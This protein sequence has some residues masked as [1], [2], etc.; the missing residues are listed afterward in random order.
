MLDY[1]IH[2]TLSGT[3]CFMPIALI[4]WLSLFF[5]LVVRIGNKSEFES[6]ELLLSTPLAITAA[7]IAYGVFFVAPSGLRHIPWHT[8]IVVILLGTQLLQ[9]IALVSYLKGVR[10]FAVFILIT[11][12][13]MSCVAG[14]EATMSATGR[15]L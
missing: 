4:T 5:A 12:I 2:S 14:L 6:R 3:F 15:W 8:W 9:S 11:E 7:L 1:M 13:C 10:G